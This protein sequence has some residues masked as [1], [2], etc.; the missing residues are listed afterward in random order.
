[1]IEDK[2]Y[3]PLPNG[4]NSYIP[5]WA[6]TNPNWN[7][8]KQF[9]FI[10]EN[11]LNIGDDW[12]AEKIQIDLFIDCMSQLT[13]S[14]S[15]IELGTS[16]IYCSIYSL[17]FEKFFN[18]NCTIINTEPR[19]ELYDSAK[20]YWKDLHL[21][22]ANFYHGFTGNFV[23]TA[24][25]SIG[26]ITID[27]C[28]KKLRISEL[29]N[30]NNLKHLDILHSDIQGQEINLLNELIEDKYLNKITYFFISTHGNDI[31]QTVYNILSSNLK[32]S[33]LFSD[34]TQGGCGDGLIV[35]KNL[36]E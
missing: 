9:D 30:D 21:I 31:H 10:Y 17:L 14:P 13:D 16:G 8:K 24:N 7:S 34:Y 3:L 11:V 29:M 15:L 32:G 12:R 5:F 1:M 2:K 6:D 22:N 27:D 33:F 18:Y 4:W 28:G 20:H 23:T 19:L 36:G 25:N 26:V 35:F